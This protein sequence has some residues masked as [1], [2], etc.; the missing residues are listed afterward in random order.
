VLSGISSTAWT[1]QLN[2][3]SVILSYK[4]TNFRKH[5]QKFPGIATNEDNVNWQIWHHNGTKC[6]KGTVP[7]RRVSHINGTTSSEAANRFTREHGYAVGHMKSQPP[8]IYGTKST[9]RQVWLVSGSY[10]VGDLN[11][12]EAGWQ[13]SHRIAIGGAIS[14]TSTFRGAQTDLTIQIW[15]DPKLGL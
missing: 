7:I 3:R 9:L 2:L 8:K 12:I 1:E 4:I 6:P 13:T 11:S 5:L 10:D 15:K 14:P